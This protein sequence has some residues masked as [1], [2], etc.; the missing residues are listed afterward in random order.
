MPAAEVRPGR[1]GGGL[2]GMAVEQPRE[3]AGPAGEAQQV[4]RM[5]FDLPDPLPGQL[6]DLGDLRERAGTVAAESEPELQHVPLAVRQEA[7]LFADLFAE[8]RE[9]GGALGAV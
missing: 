1:D 8:H 4:E 2:P 7:H 6:E 9:V 3:A 5:T